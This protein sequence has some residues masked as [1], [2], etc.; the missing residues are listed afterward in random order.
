[1]T[2]EEHLNE[3]LWTQKSLAEKAGISVVTVSNALDGKPIK[4]YIALKIANA[5]GEAKGAKIEVREIDGLVI[6]PLRLGRKSKEG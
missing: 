4:R 6:M 1:M 5:L 3:L 2:L